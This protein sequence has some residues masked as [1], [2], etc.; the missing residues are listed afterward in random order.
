MNAKYPRVR[1]SLDIEGETVVAL[2]E[3]VS[4]TFYIRRPHDE[5]AQGVLR[6]LDVYRRAIGERTLGSYVDDH[7][8]W[9]ELDEKGWALILQE[10]GDPRGANVELCER[11]DSVTGHRFRY[12]GRGR[13]NPFVTAPDSQATCGLEFWLPTE[14]LE[15]HGP[16]R[17]RELALVLGSELPFSSGYAGL[18]FEPWVWTRE[19]S[20]FVHEKSLRHPGFD[21]PQ[22]EDHTY[23][24]GTRVRG[25]AWLTFL[26]Q[27]VLGEL[28]GAAGLRARL[29][30]PDTSVQDLE[31]D[32]VV[33]TLGKEPEAGDLE[34]GLTLPHYRELAKALEPW[35]YTYQGPLGFRSR[36]EVRRW[37]RRFLD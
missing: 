7:G 6:S 26:G 29:R 14:F 24:L 12:L 5:I 19:L 35:L 28:G 30:S 4:I 18:A 27:P 15:E 17:V 9:P 3:S 32:R 25:P 11:P 2:R 10:L 21:I 37:E 33:V 23:Q 13:Q 31:G 8:N 36:D 34:Q 16:G 1:S 22:M 20:S